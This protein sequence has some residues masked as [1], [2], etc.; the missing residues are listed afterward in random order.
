MSR[1]VSSVSRASGPS[2]APVAGGGAPCG[3]AGAAGGAGGATG[4][5]YLTR[6]GAGTSASEHV[7]KLVCP[8][9]ATDDTSATSAQPVCVLQID[10]AAEIAKPGC[11]FKAIFND[12]G[13]RRPGEGTSPGNR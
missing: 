8:R 9:I 11:Q 6:E 10:P 3:R 2:A 5:G 12:H 1:G 13:P 7:A 4:F